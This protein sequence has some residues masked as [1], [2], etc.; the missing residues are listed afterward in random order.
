MNYWLMKSEPSAFSINDLEK[1]KTEHWDGVRNYQA[2]NY[3]KDM[4]KG[5][6]AF[7]YHSNS[8][9]IGIAGIAKIAKEAFPDHTQFDFSSKYFDP[10]ATK[11]NPRWFMVE[12]EFVKKFKS[13][14]P[15]ETLKTFS[16]LSD[17]IVLKKGSRL[18]IQPVTETEFQFI[19]KLAG[20]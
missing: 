10:K 17:M 16:E 18:S 20:K 11:T 5:D 3:M 4:K 19:S 14:L 8:E 13:V 9:T 15:L 6:L 7:I 1:R 12:V 2:R